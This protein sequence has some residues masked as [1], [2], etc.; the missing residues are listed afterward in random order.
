MKFLYKNIYIILFFSLSITS[1]FAQKTLAIRVTNLTSS[2]GMDCDGWLNDSDWQWTFEGAASGC[3]YKEG[4]N[5]AQNFNPN[6]VIWGTNTYYSREC[7]PSSVNVIFKYQEDDN[8]TGGG[9][10][11]SGACSRNDNRN[12]PAY[13]SANGNVAL[14]ALS[15]ICKGDCAGNITYSYNG[16]FEVGGSNF[17]GLNLDVNGYVTNKTCATAISL[18]TNTTGTLR[19]NDATQCTETWYSYQNTAN[20]TSI[21][22]DPSQNNSN[23]DIYY[24]E[25][26]TCGDMCWITSGSGAAVLRGPKNTG[27]YFIRLTS[28]NGANT[29]LVVSRSGAGSN[30]NINQ[31]TQVTLNPGTNYASNF[32]NNSYSNEPNEPFTYSGDN[33]AWYT[34]TTPADGLLRVTANISEN[35]GNNTFVTLW[36]KGANT[37]CPFDNLSLVERDRA[38]S[39]SSSSI[40]STCLSPNTTYYVQYGTVDNFSVCI[41]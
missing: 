32:N 14:G 9:C 8:I 27:T 18:G 5:S 28:S 17:N 25:A 2:P 31:A 19:T 16:N 6:R 11:N 23:V 12:T 10:N 13:N 21:T 37:N 24:S 35:G 34:F 26:E 41:G 20:V 29:N 15:G 38:C 30:D 4:T 3:E 33:S 7:W 1:V 39:A 40:E 36:K 22:F